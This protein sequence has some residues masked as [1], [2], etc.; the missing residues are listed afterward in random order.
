MPE[1]LYK[2]YHV[3]IAISGPRTVT[4]KLRALDSN[5]NPGRYVPFEEALKLAKSPGFVKSQTKDETRSELTESTRALFFNTG[6]DPKKVKDPRSFTKTMTSFVGNLEKAEQTLDRAG[7][8]VEDQEAKRFLGEMINRG[9][10]FATELLNQRLEG[11]DVSEDD[12]LVKYGIPKSFRGKILTG[13]LEVAPNGKLWTSLYGREMNKFCN[14]TIAEI[15]S[16]SE[17]N[18]RLF[19]PDGIPEEMKDLIKDQALAE[20][21]GHRNWGETPEKAREKILSKSFPIPLRVRRVEMLRRYSV[22]KALVQS[23]NVQQSAYPMVDMLINKLLEEYYMKPPTSLNL[24]KKFWEGLAH[25]ALQDPSIVSKDYR[26]QT[27]A[28]LDESPKPEELKK[29]KKEDVY[30]HPRTHVT[31]KNLRYDQALLKN[32]R[33]EDASGNEVKPKD[34]FEDYLPVE[35]IGTAKVL[36]AKQKERN[37]FVKKNDLTKKS[38]RLL[39]GLKTR[40]VAKAVTDEVERFLQSF[41][42]LDMQEMAAHIVYVTCEVSA[43][44]AREV[45]LQEEVSDSEPEDGSGEKGKEEKKEEEPL[46]DMMKE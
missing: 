45:V 10:A 39:K 31:V 18:L 4:A 34:G 30:R 6:A 15:R 22:T 38:Q 28:I 23:K 2:F 44:R 46:P 43:K 3:E 12:L 24:V 25:K 29:L 26:L 1:E 32:P 13:A 17:D 7:D 42:F 20:M 9:K 21:S 41:L 16:F 19:Y 37:S 11:N 27:I 40:G 5:G 36:T 33:Y 14:L 8:C 35:I